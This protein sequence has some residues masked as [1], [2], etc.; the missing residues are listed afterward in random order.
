MPF[1]ITLLVIAL[2]VAFLFLSTLFIV[3]SSRPILFERFGQIQQRC[4]S[5]AFIIRIPLWTVSP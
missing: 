4:S 5:P 2:I 3:R 1:L